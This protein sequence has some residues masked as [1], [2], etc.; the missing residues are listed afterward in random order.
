MASWSQVLADSPH[1][2]ARVQ[3]R[4]E[5]SRHKTMAT[6]RADGSP[7][8]S[9]TETRFVDGELTFGSMPGSRKGA[10]LHR[11]P[12]VALHSATVDPVEGQEAL[13]PG[14]AKMA[15]RVLPS[16]PLDGPPGDYFRLDITEVV[17]TRLNQSGTALM[18][19]SWHPGRGTSV[20]E[21]T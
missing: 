4:F 3:E 16:A 21:R 20:A 13:W 15:G 18:I 14:E 2:A 11:D 10:D 1:L 8:I 6:L 17:F 7:R 12:R 5:A 19:Q 9:G